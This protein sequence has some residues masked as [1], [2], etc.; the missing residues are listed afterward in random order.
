M[1]TKALTRPKYSLNQLVMHPRHGR[2]AVTFESHPP[3]LTVYRVVF[4][5]SR[6]V[7]EGNAVY[8]DYMEVYPVEGTLELPVFNCRLNGHNAAEGRGTDE[9]LARKELERLAMALAA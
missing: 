9:R 2:G 8:L 7:Y 1:S 6:F 4:K 5:D 3:G